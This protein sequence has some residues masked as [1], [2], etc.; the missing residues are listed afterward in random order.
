MT[1]FGFIPRANSGQV[2]RI[3]KE[4]KLQS[5][6]QTKQCAEFLSRSIEANIQEATAQ[7]QMFLVAQKN[8]DKR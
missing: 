5:T 3:V 2:V 1:N 6:D 7:E 4:S 8:F